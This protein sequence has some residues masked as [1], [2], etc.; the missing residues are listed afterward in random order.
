VSHSAKF[1]A[2]RATLNLRLRP[3]DPPDGPMPPK[4]LGEPLPEISSQNKDLQV[5]LTRPEGSR[6]SRAKLRARTRLGIALA[7][8]AGE[9]AERATEINPGET[10]LSAQQIGAQT[11][12]RFSRPHGHEGR[13]Q[14]YRGPAHART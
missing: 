6:I 13:P 1:P 3:V 12:P 8:A 9:P 10:D 7:R 14:G 11:P 4:S 2:S 5:T